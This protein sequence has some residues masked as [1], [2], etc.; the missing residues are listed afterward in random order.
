MPTLCQALGW[1]LTIQRK[2][3]FLL[4]ELTANQ[5]DKSSKRLQRSQE[6]ISEKAF[7]TQKVMPENWADIKLGKEYVLGKTICSRENNIYEAPGP[8][9]ARQR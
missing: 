1:M 3:Q 8:R 2:K 6:G 7:A 5:H 4:S 9:K